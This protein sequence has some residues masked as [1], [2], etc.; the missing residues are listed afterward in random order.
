MAGKG[1]AM[2]SDAERFRSEHLSALSP[3]Q[4]RLLIDQGEWIEPRAGEMLTREGQPAI[5]AELDKAT[6]AALRDKLERANRTRSE[7]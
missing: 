5:A 6:I 4:A 7:G 2:D 1:G 3:G